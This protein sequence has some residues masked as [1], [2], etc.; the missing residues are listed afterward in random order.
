ME[1]T[2]ASITKAQDAVRKT[3]TADP[4]DKGKF[5]EAVAELNRVSGIAQANA[6]RMLVELAS[7]LTAAERKALRSQPEDATLEQ[8][9]SPS[10]P[11]HRKSP[12]SH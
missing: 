10:K 1:S 5:H 7:E 9:P 4:F 3:L 12:E 2:R 8:T 6:Q 11:D